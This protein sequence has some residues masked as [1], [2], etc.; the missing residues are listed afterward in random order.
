MSAKYGEITGF[1]PDRLVRSVAEAA[2]RSYAYVLVTTKAI[3]ERVT[4]P[5]ILKPLIS[6]PYADKHP[7]PTYVFLQNGLNIEADLYH[8]ITR[9][10]AHILEGIG[11]I[12]SAGGTELTIVGEVQR[13]KFAKNFWNVSFSS[14]ATLTQHRLPAIFR[15]PPTDPSSP[16]SPYVSPTT[17]DLIAKHTIPTIRATLQELLVLGRALGYPDDKDGLPA[18][19]V[20]DVIE[21]TR[22]LHVV[23]E[24]K[25]KPSMMLDVEKGL[26]IEVEVIL[27]E[28][29]RMAQERGVS[30]PRVEMLY[31][32]LL[33]VQNQIL[34]KAEEN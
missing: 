6:S 5:A 31:A 24:S 2:D 26:P 1:R 21:N 12:L 27:G 16:Y 4:T 30:M 11:Q 34:A 32:L 28:T 17:A 19:V 25:H 20:D 18:S 9:L 22:K 3:P 7:Q 8:N 23:P 10:D 14:F 13:L 33:V 15:P 29:V